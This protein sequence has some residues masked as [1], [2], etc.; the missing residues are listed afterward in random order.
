M[1]QNTVEVDAAD[2]TADEEQ[3]DARL[4]ELL[5]LMHRQHLDRQDTRPVSS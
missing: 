1:V 5:H 3:L 2:V 4:A